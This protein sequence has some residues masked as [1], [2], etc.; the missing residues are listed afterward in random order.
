[1]ETL[2][3]EGRLS[4]LGFF[5][6]AA[7]PASYAPVRTWGELVRLSFLNSYRRLAVGVASGN[8]HWVE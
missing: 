7:G 4:P 3:N 6:A 1:M 5:G 8:L 2:N